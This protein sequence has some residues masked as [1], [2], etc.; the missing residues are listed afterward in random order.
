MGF[1]LNKMMKSGS[2]VITFA[3]PDNQDNQV[4]KHMTVLPDF[5]DFR[6]S[7]LP[8]YTGMSLLT[9]FEKKAA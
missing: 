2:P 1:G 5:C 7:V 9:F 3:I 6:I 4:L 8:Y